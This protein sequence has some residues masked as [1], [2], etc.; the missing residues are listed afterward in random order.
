MFVD[1]FFVGCVYLFILL[2]VVLW[3]K[4]CEFVDVINDVNLVYC[5]FE[6]VW[7][8]GYDDVIV[9][10]MFVIWLMFFVG[11]QVL[12]DF[13]FGLDYLWV[14][15]G[16]QYFIYDWLVCVGDVLQVVVMIEQIRVV[17]GNEMIIMCVDVM[18][19]VGEYVVIVW[20]M[21]VVRGMAV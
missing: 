10:L 7:V 15:Y 6:V 1:F 8:L 19:V 13:E 4:I 12:I 17:V 9:L 16:E 11:Y 20:V 5:D 2:Y 3:E 14:V 18:M 21:I